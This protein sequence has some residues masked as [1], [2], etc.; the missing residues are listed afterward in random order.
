M[1]RSTEEDRPPAATS[2]RRAALFRPL[3]VVGLAGVLVVG[4][5]TVALRRATDEPRSDGGPASVPPATS[6]SGGTSPDPSSG[7]AGVRFE[8]RAAGI[9]QEPSRAWGSTWA[10]IDG[11]GFPEVLVNRHLRAAE[12]L[13]LDSESGLFVSSGIVEPFLPPEGRA[14][15]DRHNCAWGEANGDGVIDMY[16]ASG[17]QKG[18]GTGPNQLLLGPDLRDVAGELGLQDQYGRGR[19]AN[20]LDIEGDGDLDLFLANEIVEGWPNLLFRNDRGTF[21][22]VDVGLTESLASSSSSWADWDNDGDPDLLLLSHGHTGARAYRNDGGRFSRTE[23][24]GISGVPWTSA[25]W[26]DVEGDGWQDLLLV[27]LDKVGYLSNEQGT[28]VSRFE[29]KLQSGEAGVWIDVDNDA[30]LDPFVVEGT[31]EKGPPRAGDNILFLNHDGRFRPAKE[32]GVEGPTVGGDSVAVVDHDRDGGLDLFMSNGHGPIKAPFQLLVNLSSRGGWVGIDLE[33]DQWN[34]LG[35]GA[36]IRV[37]AGNRVIRH[38]VTDAVTHRSQSE[39][40]YVHVGIGT[41]DRAEVVVIWPDGERSCVD[42]DVGEIVRVQ[43]ATPC[44]G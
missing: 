35:Y 28:F 19:S 8:E 44:P 40:G 22:S 10:D 36:R 41:A 42:A 31:P 23:L 9:D 17:A 26:G 25:A 43:K 6:P 16:C 21:M 11:D 3:F 38:A 37:K 2:E 30:D 14:Y 18:K 34:P 5:V 27:R 15:Y 12:L 33:G 7:G 39:V 4:G 1:R 20:W 29:H 13:T 24:P 32:A